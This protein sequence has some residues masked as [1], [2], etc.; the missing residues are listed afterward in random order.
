MPATSGFESPTA[1]NEKSIE[2]IDGAHSDSS[3]D[4]EAGSINEKALLRKLDLKL[5]PAVSLL[6]LLSFLD[7]SNGMGAL[8][9]NSISIANYCSCQCQNR[10]SRYRSPHD[11]Q[12]VP[13]RLDA[14][15]RGIRTT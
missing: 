9:F 8:D 7:R 14:L 15:L 5:L 11:R 13:D 1:D 4:Y 3:R 10:R 12:P 2:A 6:Y